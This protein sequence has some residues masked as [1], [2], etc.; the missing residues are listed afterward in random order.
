MLE[1]PECMVLVEKMKY[2]NYRGK[3]LKS[4][5]PAPLSRDLQAGFLETFEL[6]Y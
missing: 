3:R 1:K 2:W 4:D 6:I 5:T